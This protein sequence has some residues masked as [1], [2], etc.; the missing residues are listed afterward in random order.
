MSTEHPSKLEQAG[1]NLNTWI[2]IGGA[3]VGLVSACFLAGMY[4]GGFRDLPAAVESLKTTNQANFELVKNQVN[5]LSSTILQQ[6]FKTT[7]IQA[8][9][10]QLEGKVQANSDDDARQ[11]DTIRDSQ[12]KVANALTREAFLQWKADLER[13]NQNL[14]TTSL[15][16]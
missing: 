7:T 4:F 8:T 5:G 2:G 10:G 16:Q 9:L 15:P 6:D 3:A 13:R 1:A 12:A 14:Q 11:W